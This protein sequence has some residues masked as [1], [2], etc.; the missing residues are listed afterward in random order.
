[1]GIY[2]SIFYECYSLHLGCVFCKVLLLESIS[3]LIRCMEIKTVSLQKTRLL[4]LYWPKRL[5][6]GLISGISEATDETDRKLLTTGVFLA[7]IV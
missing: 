1:M 4:F 7:V 6:T 3:V 2:N 5:S